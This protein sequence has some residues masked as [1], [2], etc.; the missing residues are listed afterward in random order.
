MLTKPD[1]PEP[2]PALTLS[3]YN[4]SVAQPQL[5]AQQPEASEP[6]SAAQQMVGK[7]LITDLLQ[8]ELEVKKGT[9][10]KLAQSNGIL[11]WPNI[12]KSI[13][14]GSMSKT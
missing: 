4:Q 11:T 7:H 14:M 3:L 1:C 6:N 10:R 9:V 5:M 2:N 13:L 8:H 12:S